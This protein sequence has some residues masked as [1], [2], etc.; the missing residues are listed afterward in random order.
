MKTKCQLNNFGF[1]CNDNVSKNYLWKDGIHF[2]DKGTNILVGKFVNVFNYFVLNRNYNI[3][4]NLICLRLTDSQL[5]SN[6]I[7]GTLSEGSV[8]VSNKEFIVGE[9]IKYKE[10]IKLDKK[11]NNCY[12]HKSSDMSSCIASVLDEIRTKNINRLI[13]Y[14]LNIN[15]LSSKFEQ[16]KVLIQ[17]K[18]DILV[19]TETKFVIIHIKEDMPSKKLRF[20]NMAENLESIFVEINRY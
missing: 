6:Q 15:S 13:I 17:R 16:L 5:Y 14:N 1:T 2:T 11:D 4:N 8:G 20:F 18:I 10:P 12:E 19:I 3:N 9:G 7:S